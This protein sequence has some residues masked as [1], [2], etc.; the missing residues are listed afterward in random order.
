LSS[1]LVIIPEQLA[2]II[3]ATDYLSWGVLDI[4]KRRHARQHDVER[5]GRRRIRANG[6]T[7]RSND[8]V[9]RHII[10]QE[11]TTL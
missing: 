5:G 4:R 3:S 2:R 11:S 10:R 1:Q 9:G 6:A 7:L 8:P